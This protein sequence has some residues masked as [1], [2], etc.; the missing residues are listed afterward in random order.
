MKILVPVKR[1]VDANIKV[2]LGA[3]GTLDVSSLKK[4]M[5]P[6]DEIA[7][8][9]AVQMKE[10]GIAH[11][12]IAVSVGEAQCAETL[13]VALAMGAD[14]AVLLQTSQA[15][16]LE[17]L[18]VAK[19]LAAYVNQST[20]DL[21]ICG[22]QAVDDDANQVGQ[23]V[24]AL[25]GYPQGTH[26]SGAEMKEGRL[27]VTREVDGGFEVV[28]L[29]LPAV[30]TADLRLNAPRYVTLPMMM[31]AKRKPQVVIEAASLGVQLRAHTE[32]V[33]YE[34][35]AARKVGQRVASVDE[36]IDKLKN[37]AKVL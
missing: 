13:R 33:G 37:E 12:V 20:P 22:K 5:N 23:M 29:T 21:I 35:P 19:I 6:F 25:C 10:K 27:V 4:S 34:A 16:E 36:L 30:V 24:A 17:P 3:D 28:E 11:E 15:Y 2:K 14:K 18:N 9:Q 7:L 1:V 32:V 26:A 31:K 8:E